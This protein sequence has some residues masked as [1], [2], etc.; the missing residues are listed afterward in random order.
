MGNRSTHLPGEAS[1]FCNNLEKI[2]IFHAGCDREF[3]LGVRA[4]NVLIDEVLG[5]D[6][7][8]S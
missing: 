2:R 5:R 8:D 1:R 6:T 3:R 4:G 7:A